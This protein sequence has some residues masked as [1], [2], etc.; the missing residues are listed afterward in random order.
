MRYKFWPYYED[1]I[2]ISG[3]D[4]APRE[5]VEAANAL[6]KFTEKIEARLGKTTERIG[7]EH[8]ISASRKKVY[9]SLDPMIWLSKENKLIAAS[10]I[11]TND[12]N[13]D[14]FFSV[15]DEDRQEMVNTILA[16]RI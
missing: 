16:G 7:Y 15:L 4:R 12:K 9:A 14:L 8:Y 11:T 5:H 10:W 2:E 3:K 1:W 6:E 13:V